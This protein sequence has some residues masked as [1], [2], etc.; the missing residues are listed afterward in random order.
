MKLPIHVFGDPLLKKEAIEIDA[1][2]PELAALIANMFETMAASSGVGLAAPQVGHS[3][4]LFIIDAEGYAKDYPD[5]AGFRK[6]F[7]NPFI[8]EESGE[9]WTFNEG[10][11]SVP[12]I[13]EE[14]LRKPIVKL[15]YLDEAFQQHEE[16]FSGVIARIIQHEYDHLQGKL[17]VERISSFKR[18]LLRR[19]LNNIVKG[20]VDV[21]YKIKIPSTLKRK[22]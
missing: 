2:Y 1:S 13:R 10:C 21:D 18:T 22:I 17:F 4:R 8:I 14:V 3:I 15:R 16:V 5:V 12:G 19:R 20:D 11:L 6:V 9:P 7:I